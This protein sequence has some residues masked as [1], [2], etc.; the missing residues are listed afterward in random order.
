MDGLQHD[1]NVH[2]I[3]DETSRYLTLKSLCVK[4]QRILKVQNLEIGMM[5]SE[6][7]EVTE[8]KDHWRNKYFDLM[9][10]IKTISNEGLEEIQEA[11]R[12][13]Q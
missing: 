12:S 13:D 4:Q 1:K 7:S 3:G 8:M 10:K 9:E 11:D 5:K 6:I 2:T